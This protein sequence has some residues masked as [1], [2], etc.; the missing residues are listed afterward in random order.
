MDLG[1]GGAQ[2]RPSEVW[3]IKVKSVT[4]TPAPELPVKV[5][6]SLEATNVVVESVSTSEPPVEVST[7][8][9]NVLPSEGYED[10]DDSED[11]VDYKD[12]VVPADGDK[13]VN[14]ECTT[15]W[16]IPGQECR[17]DHPRV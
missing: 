2:M 13:V 12:V 7:D 17:Q 14:N 1:E 10:A 3:A 11:D 15:S 4:S 8:P 16:S 9:P 6:D 5:A